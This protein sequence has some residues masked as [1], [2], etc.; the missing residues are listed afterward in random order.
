MAS[1]KGKNSDNKRRTGRNIIITVIVCITLFIFK[2]RVASAFGFLD[3][4][5]QTVNFKMVKV[6][7]IIYKQTLKFKSRIHDLNYID[8]YEDNNKERF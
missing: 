3:G 2:D 6:K 1:K 5:A 8:S 4:M 7:S